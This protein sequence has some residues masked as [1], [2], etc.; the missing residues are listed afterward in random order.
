MV[1][2]EQYEDRRNQIPIPF[3][4]PK[5]KLVLVIF[6]LIALASAAPNPK[7]KGGQKAALF[8]LYKENGSFTHLTQVEDTLR[9]SFFYNNTETLEKENE[10]FLLVEFEDKEVGT[11]YFTDAE[12]EHPTEA[13]TFSFEESFN[14]L[15]VSRT[16][17]PNGGILQILAPTATAFYANIVQD[18]QLTS[19]SAK[20]FL[21][22]KAQST[23]ARL[24]PSLLMML[25]MIVPRI[26]GARNMS[27]RQAQQPPATP[28]PADSENVE[29]QHEQVEEL[30]DEDESTVRER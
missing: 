24:L 9:G 20:K 25:V 17:L 4:N 15:Q 28:A 1:T 21:V 23:L 19:V 2:F 11:V 14:G 16:N 27:R 12:G 29:P 6:V 22:H 13:F 30:P 7:S 10:K 18:G 8:D 3:L 5:M 26:I